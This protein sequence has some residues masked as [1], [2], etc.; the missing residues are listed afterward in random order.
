MSRRQDSNWIATAISTT[1]AGDKAVIVNSDPN[2]QI[3]VRQLAVSVGSLDGTTLT[4]KDSGG[5][6]L[7]PFPL[8]TGLTLE[9]PDDMEFLFACAPGTDLV[10]NVLDNVAVGG[11]IWYAVKSFR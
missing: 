4:F 2:A 6:L 5:Q 8:T 7:G 3:Q 1:G 10:M 11:I 9:R